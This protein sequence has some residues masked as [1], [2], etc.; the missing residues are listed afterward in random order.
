VCSTS[1]SF[2]TIANSSRQASGGFSLFGGKAEKWE[3]AADQ[4]ISAA[5]AFRMQKQSQI[6][7]VVI[8]ATPVLI[9]VS[10]SRSG[11][12]FRESSFDSVNQTLRTR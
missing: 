12:M 2:E 5:N 6:A 4:Y 1:K 8:V 10:R 3:A 7:L 11:T 9:F